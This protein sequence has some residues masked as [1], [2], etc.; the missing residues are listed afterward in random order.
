ME[1]K[2]EMFKRLLPIPVTLITTVDRNG[3]PNAAPYGCVMPIL[4]PLDLIAIASALPRDTLKNIRETEEF[5]VNVMGR[6]SFEKAIRCAKNFPPEVN[7]LEEVGLEA[8]AS[9]KIKPP[10]VKDAIGWIEARLEREVTGENYSIIIGK[11]VLAEVND[12]FLSK[13]SRLTE[14]PVI[15][16]MPYFMLPERKVA[17]AE[18]FK[19]IT[20]DIKF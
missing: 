16:V 1:L 12:R 17:E 6:P 10:R 5:V 19:D 20:S 3:I 13:D 15:F 8:E 14:P 2:P 18:S 7:E 4:R 11:V 9:K